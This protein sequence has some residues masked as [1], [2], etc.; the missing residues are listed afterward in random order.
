M[1]KY[2]TLASRGRY[3]GENGSV[4]QHAEPCFDGY[5]NS[6]TTVEKD[7]YILEIEEEGDGYGQQEI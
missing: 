5:I 2:V 1:K 3:I 7:N 6:L 4:K